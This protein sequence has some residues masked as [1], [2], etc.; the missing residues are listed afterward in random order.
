MHAI[1]VAH[2]VNIPLIGLFIFLLILFR[3]FRGRF[4][5]A[6][7][8]RAE[9]RVNH[10]PAMAGPPCP[11]VDRAEAKNAIGMNKGD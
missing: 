2:A 6:V 4:S 3:D 10:P 11:G 7:I 8:N 9:I 5:A 1:A